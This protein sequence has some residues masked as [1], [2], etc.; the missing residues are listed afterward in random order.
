MNFDQ[1]FIISLTSVEFGCNLIL[2]FVC[3]NEFFLGSPQVK[4]YLHILMYLAYNLD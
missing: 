2:K 3:R 1:V 4:S